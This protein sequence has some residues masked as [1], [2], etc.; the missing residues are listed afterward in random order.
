MVTASPEEWTP[1]QV[2]E[3]ER[4]WAE[5]MADPRQQRLRELKAAKG[6]DDH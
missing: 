6:S 2:A 3:F 4:A 1:E 5:R